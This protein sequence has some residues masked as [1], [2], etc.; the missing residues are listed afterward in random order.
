MSKKLMAAIA[1]L[2][3]SIPLCNHRN[4]DLEAASYVEAILA[5][6]R[7]YRELTAMFWERIQDFQAVDKSHVPP[8]L[9]RKNNEAAGEWLDRCYEKG[10][11]A[12]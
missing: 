9:C 10:G 4:F 3:L 7:R 5:E 11:Y 2:R 6:P 1:G 12:R 8:A